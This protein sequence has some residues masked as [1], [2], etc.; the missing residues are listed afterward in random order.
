MRILVVGVKWPPETFI[1][2]KLERLRK[3]GY[4]LTVATHS[5]HRNSA[6]HPRLRLIRLCKW[7]EAL[8]RRLPRLAL[9]TVRGLLRSPSFMVRA[10]A[11]ARRSAE[12]RGDWI[13]RFYRL[14]PFA[15]LETDVIHFDWNFAAVDYAELFDLYHCPSLISCRGSQLQ[16]APKNPARAAQVGG[17]RGTLQ[18]ATMIHCVSDAILDQAAA[19][20]MDPKKA[21][22]IRPAVDP[23]FFRPLRTDER[24]RDKFAVISV[25]NLSWVKGHQYSLESIRLLKERGVPVSFTIVGEGSRQDYQHVRFTVHDLGLEQDVTMLGPAD[26]EEVRNQLRS[27][28]AFLLSSVSEGISNAVLEAMSCG[29][30]VVTSDCGGMREAVTHR[31]EGFV[32]PTRDPGAAA[33]ALFELARNPDLGRSMGE[34]ARMRV[35]REFSLDGQVQQLSDMYETVTRG[36]CRGPREQSFAAT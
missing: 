11:V 30:P 23:T 3:A 22:V 28:D 5:E 10:F 29:L 16:I 9:L 4:E 36:L 33:E 35:L 7:S 31:I 12:T 15:G 27:S 6:R 25:G 1:A 20:G 13:R 21:R 34:A 14:L 17:L 8:P 32:V 24:S 2:A 18:R 19:L 26:Q